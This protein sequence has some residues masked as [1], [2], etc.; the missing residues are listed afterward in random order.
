MS[1]L[2]VLKGKMVDPTWPG[3]HGGGNIITT[4]L[5]AMVKWGRRSSLWPMPF[6][7]ACCAIEFM[8]VSASHY[9]ISRFGAEVLRFSPRQSDLLFVAGTIP[10]KL[11][12]SCKHDLR[13]DV[14]AELGDLDGRLRL[15]GRLLPLVPRHAGHRRDH[16]RGRLRARL[17]AR[18]RGPRRRA[19]EDPGEDQEGRAGPKP[20][21]GAHRLGAQGAG[22]IDRRAR[23]AAPG[24][25]DDA[26]RAT[27]KGRRPAG[28]SSCR[29]VPDDETG[30]RTTMASVD[31]RPSR[32][33]TSEPKGP[34]ARLLA[35]GAR[36][37]RSSRVDRVPRR[38]RD[39]R[40]PPRAW[41]RGGDAPAR[42][43]RARLPL[44]LDLC[45]VDYLD[46]RPA[47][48]ATR[49]C[50]TSTPSR[51]KHHVRLKTPV[52]ETDADA[53]HAHR[54]LQGRQLVRA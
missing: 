11:A 28:A 20:P 42:P 29:C 15:V 32:Q 24:R 38:P 36:R 34:A 41:R 31:H 1:L 44:F 17:P 16:P 23:R 50:C 19:H 5:D 8:A 13:P 49:W 54:R 46:V 6:G 33:P 10:D 12:P 51:T 22:A 18:A 35:R 9:D 7:T 4:S 40:R 30:R 2:D 47:A 45:G 39:H 53:R 48:S 43:P 26:A 21:Q 52:P 14:R 37:P 25:Q 27:R 3:V